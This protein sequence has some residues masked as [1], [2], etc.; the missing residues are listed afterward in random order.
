MPFI[1]GGMLFGVNKG[2][3]SNLRARSILQFISIHSKFCQSAKYG[4]LYILYYVLYIVFFTT[5][6]DL[7]AKYCQFC[8]R[9][10]ANYISDRLLIY[11]YNISY[12]KWYTKI[13]IGHCLLVFSKL[14]H[15]TTSEYKP[16]GRN[17]FIAFSVYYAR[18][19]R[20]CTKI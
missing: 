15:F 5:G 1:P 14:C 11:Q 8:V 12:E 2:L 20:G 13:N 10:V 4:V 3:L 18:L 9:L 17:A 19:V 7:C 6:R 16:G